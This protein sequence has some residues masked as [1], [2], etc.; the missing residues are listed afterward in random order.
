[1]WGGLMN[2]SVSRSEV[3]ASG[4]CDPTIRSHSRPTAHFDVSDHSQPLM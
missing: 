2:A 4:S 1:M 3:P